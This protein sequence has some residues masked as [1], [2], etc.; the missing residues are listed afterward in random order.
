MLACEGCRA[1]GEKPARVARSTEGKGARGGRDKVSSPCKGRWETRGTY[2]RRYPCSGC[3]RGGEEGARA[4]GGRGGRSLQTETIRRR[5]GQLQRTSPPSSHL[6]RLRPT[7][8]LLASF[9]FP[10]TYT[11]RD[12]L[13]NARLPAVR[14]RSFPAT[15]A[16]PELLAGLY[17]GA[18]SAHG[19]GQRA[20]WREGA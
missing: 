19:E 13:C 9:G 17:V 1:D 8:A 20:G 15:P 3:G 14:P 10:I 7:P 18:R 12:P 2:S 11:P 4:E 16:G 6:S 5:E